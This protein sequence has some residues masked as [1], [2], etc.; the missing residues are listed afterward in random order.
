MGKNKQ[1]TPSH[2]GTNLKEQDTP[3]VEL[4]GIFYS[5]LAWLAVSRK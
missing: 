2:W 3:R 1:A 4:V 5:R